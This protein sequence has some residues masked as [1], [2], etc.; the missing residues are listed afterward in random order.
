MKTAQYA[1]PMELVTIGIRPGEMLLETIRQAIARHEIRTGVVVSGVGTLKTCR[2]H[3]V[4]H[5]RF[6]PTDE[7]YT[8]QEPLELLSVSGIIAE[9]EPH[10]HVVVSCKQEGVWGGHLEPGS[11]VLYLAEIAILKLTRLELTRTEDPEFKTKVLGP[12]Q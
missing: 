8:L 10:L 12:K 2:M 7:F 4:T 9:G 3:Y 5:T 11:E 6:P 1:G